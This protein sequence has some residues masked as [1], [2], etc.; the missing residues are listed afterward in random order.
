MTYRTVHLDN[1]QQNKNNLICFI[2]FLKLLPEVLYDT[3]GYARYT[4][5]FYTRTTVSGAQRPEGGRR[6]TWPAILGVI[7]GLSYRKNVSQF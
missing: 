6:R 4:R 1:M 2:L 7:Q 5:L 3:V